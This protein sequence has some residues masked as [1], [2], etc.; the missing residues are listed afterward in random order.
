VIQAELAEVAAHRT[1]L[2][3]AHRLSTIVNADQII[4]LDHGRIVER[5]THAQLLARDGAY[6]RLWA[7]QQR[8]DETD[9][10]PA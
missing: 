5:G 3:I 8:E 7:L 9:K 4:V 10:T 2:V 1:S 6:A